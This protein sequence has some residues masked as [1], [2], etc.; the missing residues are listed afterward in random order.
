MI[1]IEKMVKTYE[2]K[3][4]VKMKISTF[5]SGFFNFFETDFPLF[6]LHQVATL[7]FF[8]IVGANFFLQKESMYF[9]DFFLIH[10]ATIY[11]EVS[12]LLTFFSCFFLSGRELQIKAL[13]IL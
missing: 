13:F 6:E 3:K 8:L 11:G 12:R 7:V 1:Q 4:L 10:L 5:F 9:Y 2:L